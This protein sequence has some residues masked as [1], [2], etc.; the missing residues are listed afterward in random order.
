MKP[1]PGFGG[2]CF[3]KDTSAL[4]RIAED[5]GYEFG[6]LRGVN[7][8]NTEQF[9]RVT[10]KVVDMAGGSVEGLPIAVWGLTFKARTDD[11]RMSPALE[12]VRRLVERGASVRAYDPAVN[13]PLEAPGLADV[14]V[15]R[16]PY[17]ACEGAAVLV[18]LTEWDDF[19]RLD[20]AKVAGLLETP[21]VVDGRNLLDP[22]ALRRRGFAYE[23]IGR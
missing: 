2:S 10:R 5:A 23:G 6:L 11:L 15:C 8:V 13:A 22:A 18:V 16:D 1:G 9:E 3:P 19:R 7:Q 12:V 14:A 20:F 4:I 17:G 21:R